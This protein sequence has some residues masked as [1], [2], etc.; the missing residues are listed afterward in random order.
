MHTYVHLKRITMRVEM[1]LSRMTLKGTSLDLPPFYAFTKDILTEPKEIFISIAV[2]E[3]A[4]NK[5]EACY[6]L[7]GRV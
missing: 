2:P 3:C 1:F 7:L 4:R 5:K 6:F